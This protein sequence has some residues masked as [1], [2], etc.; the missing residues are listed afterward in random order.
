[1]RSDR[2]LVCAALVAASGAASSLAQTN[3]SAPG[4]P[5]QVADVI[6]VTGTKTAHIA[7]EAPVV[8]QVITR[9]EI[10]RTTSGG[11]SQLLDEIPDIYIRQNDEFRMGASTIRMQGADP[12]KVAVLVDGRR[13]RGGID[14]VVDIRDIP[15]DYVDRIEI[16]RGPASSLYGSDAMAGVINIITRRPGPDPDLSANLALGTFGRVKGGATLGMQLDRLDYFLSYSHDEL[17]IA[18]QFG[19]FSSQ[20]EGENSDEKQTRDDVFGRIGYELGDAHRLEAAANYNPI[21]EGPQSDRENL[22]ANGSWTWTPSLGTTFDASGSWYGF[23]R[24]NTLVSFDEDAAY[25]DFVGEARFT[26]DLLRGLF[27]ETHLLTV[28]H[29]F[30]FETLESE[31]NAQVVDASATHNSTYIQDEITLS[32]AWT[33]VLGS[34]FDVHQYYGLEANP[35]LHATYRPNEIYRFSAGIGRGYRAPDLRQLFDVDVN[36]AGTPAAYVILGNRN[37]DPETDIGI[38]LFAE[39]RPRAGIRLSLGLFRHE[40]RDLIESEL[41]CIREPVGC[42]D[43]S[44]SPFP[45]VPTVNLFRNIENA[46]TQGGDL[47][48]EVEPL[49]ILRLEAA[50]RHELAVALRY[51]YLHTRNETDL[52]AIGDEL[53][54]RPPHRF[55]PSI[56]YEYRPWRAQ[57]RFVA[58]YEDEAFADI[59]NSEKVDAHWL[60]GGRVRWTVPEAAWTA[61]SG[62]S[63]S[64][65]APLSVYLEGSNLLDDE[66][67]D[68]ET[69]RGR[70]AG[71]RMIV[72]GIELSL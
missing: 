23:R 8:T 43:G 28:G 20:F 70:V 19:E 71:R 46:V 36:F 2:F 34:S 18:Q 40:F 39:A 22:A 60:I 44:E 53:P 7:S 26:H 30:R 32:E 47:A 48:I 41:I 27:S 49:A 63:W 24:T 57:L 59:S 17:E 72:G 1:M 38:T 54:F 42:F 56:F 55:V 4:Q 61:L 31:S 35:R 51:G 67:G 69:A 37:L 21:R 45:S 14:G 9:G 68:V 5:V 25:D 12:N 65:G 15:L 16:L 6:T 50:A 11:I 66:F 62:P 13:Y 52:P 64:R 29:R 33:V 10:E 58:E 3:E